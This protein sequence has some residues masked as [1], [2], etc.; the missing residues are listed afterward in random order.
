MNCNAY[1]SYESVCDSLITTRMSQF[2]IPSLQ[3][4]E[5]IEDWQ[6]L[7]T[8]A[9]TT[10]LAKPAGE[11]LALGPLPGYVKRRPAEVESIREVIELESLDDMFK[12]F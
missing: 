2:V 7:F 5:R 6:P 1:T 11:K 9:V 3:P 4:G 8:A 10:L 12:L